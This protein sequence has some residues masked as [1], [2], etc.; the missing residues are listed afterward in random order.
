[1]TEFDHF[2]TKLFKFLKDLKANNNRDWFKERKDRYEDDLRTPVLDFVRSMEDPLLT[3]SP[4]FVASD[5]KSG[6]SLMRIY[7]DTR[8][9]KDKTPYKTNA[10]IHFKHEEGK[11][12]HAPGYYLHLDNNE[13]FLGLGMWGPET[14]ILF[15]IRTAIVDDPDAY[16]KIINAK[17]FKSTF[18]LGG[19]S[20]KRAP[21][22]FDPEDPM[23]IEL[24]R[25]SFIA[26][27]NYSK[28]EL[29]SPGFKK[30]LIAD[31]K[32]GNAFVK[33]LCEC[34]DIPF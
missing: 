14:K 22:G 18:E 33:F 7:R 23:I 2:N 27:K 5:K 24:R 28:K 31:M 1:M 16:K 12:V 30:L 34:I 32:T 21:K 17:K 6:G 26:V 15:K 29:T 9:G 20:L 11:D 3:I 19:S 13:C 10:G 4:H 25:K 8:F